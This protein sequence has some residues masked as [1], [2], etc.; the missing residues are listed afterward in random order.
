[1]AYSFVTARVLGLRLLRD[2]GVT[3]LDPAANVPVP[4]GPTDLDDVTRAINSAL[5]S[6]FSKQS[7]EEKEQNLG[8]WLN[9]PT[10]VT[11]SV[12]AQSGAIASFTGWATWMTGC[13]I[14]LSGDPQDNEVT[15]QT[16]LARPYAGN[17]SSTVQAT[18]YGDCVQLSG[19]VAKVLNPLSLPN[20]SP[21]I[22]CTDRWTFMRMSGYPLVTN[23]DGSAYGYPFFWFVQKIIQRPRFWFLESAYTAGLGYVPRRIRVGPMPDQGYSLAYKAASAAQGISATDIDNDDHT[24]DPGV[25]FPLADNRVESLLEPFCRQRLTG[26]TQFK[27][28]GCKAEIMRAFQE[29]NQ[30]LNNLRAQGAPQYARYV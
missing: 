23:A 12:T 24:T 5:Q 13:T 8:A 1:M 11:L 14:R 21:L 28:D 27:N 18:V 10:Q 30:E 20:Q 6:I 4:I 9:A 17:T 29:A 7:L 22:S 3:S 26:M 25:L 16:L 19:S 15:S 2:F